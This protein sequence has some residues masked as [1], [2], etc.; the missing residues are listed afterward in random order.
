MCYHSKNT[1]LPY[2]WTEFA[3]PREAMCNAFTKY[4]A[5]Y[6]HFL[7]SDA[8]GALE[9]EDQDACLTY[10]NPWVLFESVFY[11]SQAIIHL[12]SIY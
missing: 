1:V 10:I 6:S 7:A 5:S 8:Q 2:I 4:K 12:T 9:I 3:I 11:I